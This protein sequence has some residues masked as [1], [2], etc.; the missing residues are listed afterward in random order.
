MSTLEALSAAV[1]GAENRPELYGIL[2]SKILLRVLNECSID[3]L[4]QM[5]AI[6]LEN[7]AVHHD[8]KAKALAE[9]T[10]KGDRHG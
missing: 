3:P 5:C 8:S 4:R 1:A 9:G 10:W 2:T 6:Q 7:G